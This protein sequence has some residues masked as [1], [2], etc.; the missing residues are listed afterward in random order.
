[1][2]I[3][4]VCVRMGL[5][6]SH[7]CDTSRVWQCSFLSIFPGKLK[8][9]IDRQEDSVR[10]KVLAAMCFKKAW[11]TKVDDELGVPWLR[12]HDA[13]QPPKHEGEIAE[14]SHPQSLARSSCFIYS[15]VNFLLSMLPWTHAVVFSAFKTLVEE[16]GKEEEK[17]REAK[18]AKAER[19]KRKAAADAAAAAAESDLKAKEAA[20]AAAAANAAASAKDIAA[21]EDAAVSAQ[22]EVFANATQRTFFTYFVACSLHSNA[23]VRPL[24]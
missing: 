18:V 10:F 4:A 3:A 19:E 16:A 7:V 6:S 8:S 17:A 14:N 5:E 24:A 12:M 22:Q 21:K 23:P 2:C 11:D 9:S 13:L 15:L 20:A 1:M